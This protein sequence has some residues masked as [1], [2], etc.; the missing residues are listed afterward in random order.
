[1]WCLQTGLEPLKEPMN[2][3]IFGPLEILNTCDKQLLGIMQYADLMWDAIY[4]TYPPNQNLCI[5]M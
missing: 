3:G 1:M 2:W 5:L 4:E